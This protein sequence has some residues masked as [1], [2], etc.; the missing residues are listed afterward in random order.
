MVTVR[1]R[2]GPRKGRGKTMGRIVA[3][4]VCVIPVLVIAL[5]RASGQEARAVANVAGAKSLA[6]C[7]PL[8]DLV[9]Y[10]EFDG[11]NDHAD[12]WRNS[13]ACKL[14]ND[15]RLGAV[16]ED[17]VLQGTE[18]AQETV[19]RDKRVR[20]PEV[21]SLLRHIARNGF[22]LGISR[23]GRDDWRFVAVVRNGDRPEVKRLLEIA[24]AGVRRD[25]DEANANLHRIAADGRTLFQLGASVRWLVD[26]GDLILTSTTNADV[27]LA[28]LAGKQQSAMD[29]SLRAKLAKANDGFLPAAIGFVD[30][31]S[32]EPDERAAELDSLKR[33]ELRWGFQDSALLTRVRVVAPEPRGGLAALLD[34][35]AFGVD[36]LPPL[37]VGLTHVSVLSIDLAK[38]YDQIEKVMRLAYPK[39]PTDPPSVGILARHGVDVRND[40]V[41]HLGPKLVFYVQAPRNGDTTTTAS[42]LMS[43]VAGFTLAA[44]VRDESAVSSAIDSLI[45]SFNPILREQL[46]GMPRQP[47][48]RSL[49]FLK[50]AKAVGPRPVYVLDLPRDTMP[51]PYVKALR[52]TVIVSHDQLVVSASRLAADQSVAAGAAWRP[53]EEFGPVVAT[54]PAEMIYLSLND[55]RASTSFFLRT[56][57]ILVRQINAEMATSQRAQG[58][59]PADVMVRLDQELVPRAEELNRLLFPSSTT[60]VVDREGAILTHREAIPTL[61]SPAVPAALLALLL[62]AYETSREAAQ[63]LRC[64]NNLQQIALAFHNYHAANNAFPRPAIMSEKGAAL[65]SWRVAILPYIEQQELYNK[66][67]QDE[68]WDSPHNKALLK[69]MPP[70]FVCPSQTR[71]EPFTTTYRVFVGNGA[72]FEKNK[73]IG[74]AAVTDGTAN[75]IMVVEAKEPIPWTKPDDLSFDPVAAP[76]L[77]GAGSLHRGG[78]NA[79]LANG[80]VRFIK[81]TIDLN[82]F[83]ALI[84][85]AAGEVIGAGAY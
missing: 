64:A 57:P 27:I 76:S 4:F 36:S 74:V 53:A 73:D 47:F 52:P 33:I 67:K 29:H 69:E 51:E 81:S 66:F 70:T 32:L 58:K 7:V 15:T 83:R 22:V 10:L 19:P 62:P 63:R 12:A 21:I 54:L 23:K 60:L 1:M 55:P 6:Q 44:Q 14:L 20:G 8:R 78:F 68:P 85:R 30:F 72:L 84:T 41:P 46:R 59:V 77:Q 82:V 40:L 79:S 61:T 2:L 43:H 42:L 16:I 24:D 31:D 3:I 17:L 35:P 26:K 71:V 56:L 37:P 80:S 48:E 49:A 25:G 28:T 9:L 34:Q 65:L 13:A 45:K 39:S 38:S 75:T 5:G 50:F 18:L 11:L